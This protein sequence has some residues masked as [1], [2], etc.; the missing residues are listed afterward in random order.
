MPA[1]R[2]GEACEHFLD[3]F[4]KYNFLTPLTPIYKAGSD[5]Y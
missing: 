1:L 4:S 3:E 2:L 5:H